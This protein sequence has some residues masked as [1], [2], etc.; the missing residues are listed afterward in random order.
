MRAQTQHGLVPF[1]TT[2]SNENTGLKPI[3]IHERHE[4]IVAGVLSC[5]TGYR[6]EKWLE[7]F[8]IPEVLYLASRPLMQ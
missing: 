1:G 6:P 7:P 5:D 4:T 2:K 8:F 3:A